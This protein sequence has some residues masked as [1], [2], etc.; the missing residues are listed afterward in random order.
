MANAKYDVGDILTFC[1][2]DRCYVTAV[3]VKWHITSTYI[4]GITLERHT[5]Y[6]VFIKAN[7]DD[8]RFIHEAPECV[9][10][11]YKIAGHINI[12]GMPNDTVKNNL[13][14]ATAHEFCEKRIPYVILAYWDIMKMNEKNC[15]YDGRDKLEDENKQLKKDLGSANDKIFELNKE[16]DRMRDS[17]RNDRFRIATNLRKIGFTS[18]AI[19]NIIETD[20][21]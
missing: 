15:H 9:F 14:D 13:I 12:S 8:F 1:V 19:R 3:I 11:N 18:E 20:M 16:I 7:G 21:V 6:D 17:Y 4:E 2:E 10:C 5:D